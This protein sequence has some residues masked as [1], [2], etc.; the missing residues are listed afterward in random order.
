MLTTGAPD[1]LH[2]VGFLTGGVLY[3]MLFVMVARSPARTDRL[4]L[5]TA[6]LGLAWNVGELLASAAHAISLVG[7]TEWFAAASFAA[8]GL[9]AAVVVH[10]ACRVPWPARP[11]TLAR[12]VIAVAYSSAVV[13]AGLHIAAATQRQSL[14][15]SLGLSLVSGVLAALFI[16]LVV[17]TR[18]DAQ[19][20]RALLLAGLAVFAVSAIHLGQFHGGGR[21]PW[22][23]ELL[24]HHASILVAFVILYQDYR[25]ALADLFL[26]QAL[27]LL[28]LVAI[29]FGGYSLVSPL[30]EQNT[31]A[32]SPVAVGAL[33]ALWM[34][35]ALCFPFVRVY[36]TLFV[37][38]VMLGRRDYD[39]LAAQ[40]GAT[41]EQHDSVE[42]ALNHACALLASAL[43]ATDVTWV[44]RDASPAAD[45]TSREVLIGTAD[46]P[47]PVLVIGSLAGGRRLLSDDLVMLNRVAMILARRIDA[48]RLTEERYE[49]MLH[50]R[51]IR[52]L[53][54]EAELRA[55]RA[56]I[57][58]HFLFNALTTVGYLIQ[59]TPAKALQTLMRL[60]TLLRSVLRS[61]GEFTTLGRERELVDCYLQI[62]AARFEERLTVTIDIPADLWDIAIPSV[63]VQPLVENAIKHGI[64]QARLGGAVEVSAHR[65][66]GTGQLVIQ[67]RNTGAPFTARKPRADS[68]VGLANVERRLKCYF[69][70]DAS[71]D[72]RRI[73]DGSTV[74]ELRIPVLSE[75]DRN[76]ALVSG[77][78]VS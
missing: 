23:V 26:K 14:P 56:Q 63:I 68:G 54:T 57:N 46:A 64:A 18:R 12:V 69:D 20:Q 27:T 77:G 48:L 1:L 58:P 32:P 50:E 11:G 17:L 59:H 38:R 74:A 44:Q 30:L 47:R 33:L 4:V 40:L 35:T 21:E 43:T 52:T 51:E 42:T 9:L 5:A 39:E 76:V 22:P 41:V 28:A 49:R 73:S 19:S 62:E 53:A 10:S 75:E 67:V 37:D 70:N 34:A 6:I 15:S 29:V 36:I 8:L 7:I 16:P 24:G 60:T 13:A 45:T 31:H 78:A 2:F 61:E 55:L 65:D 66:E 72:V 71:V 3:A 25:F